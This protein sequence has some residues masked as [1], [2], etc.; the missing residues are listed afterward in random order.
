V[1]AATCGMTGPTG[2]V[3]GVTFAATGVTLRKIGACCARM[4]GGEITKQLAANSA[5][6]AVTGVTSGVIAATCATIVRI[7]GR[8]AEICALTGGNSLKLV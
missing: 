1:I 2:G 4:F 8:T 3:T 6:F 7:S 5:I